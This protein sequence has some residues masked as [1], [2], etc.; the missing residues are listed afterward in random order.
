M[1]RR[2]KVELFEMIRR[3]HAAGETIQGLSKKHG[4]YRRMVRQAL[5][6]A[7]PPERKPVVREAPRLGL[8]KEHIDQMMAL[9]LRANRPHMVQSKMRAG[10]GI[11]PSWDET[12]RLPIQ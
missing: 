3:G 11:R 6:S 12:H 10:A 9:D 7:I 8:V 4:V 2:H 1:D 5:S